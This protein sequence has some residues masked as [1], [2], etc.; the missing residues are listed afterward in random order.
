M[1]LGVM[2]SGIVRFAA[3]GAIAGGLLRIFYLGWD[4]TTSTIVNVVGLAL[5]SVG[6]AIAGSAAYGALR[7]P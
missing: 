7:K 2:S 5:Y 6:G 1:A 3:L 4:P